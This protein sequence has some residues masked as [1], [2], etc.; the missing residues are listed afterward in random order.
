MWPISSHL[1]DLFFSWIW[2]KAIVFHII[3]SRFSHIEDQDV[4][5][6]LECESE[7]SDES[8]PKNSHD[9]DD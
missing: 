7:A 5:D 8:D 4:D 6:G 2:Y 9:S 3:T 1:S